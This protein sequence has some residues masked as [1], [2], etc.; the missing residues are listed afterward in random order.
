MNSKQA[1]TLINTAR[2]AGAVGNNPSTLRA[3]RDHLRKTPYKQPVCILD[4]GCGPARRHVHELQ[5]W[6]E[7][8]GISATVYGLDLADSAE[9][10]Q[11]MLAR[12]FNVVYASN[13]LN[14]Q[15]N[16]PWLNYT[17][18]QLKNYAQT[19][20]TVFANYPNNPRKLGWNKA[21]MREH[22]LSIGFTLTV[23]MAHKHVWRLT[24]QNFPLS[25]SI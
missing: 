5:Q 15:P 24:W 16:I 10:Q 6:C 12:T 23:H 1:Q 9:H 11:K 25:R 8:Q 7:A 4:Y 14:V 17:L 21:T 20:A 13:V 18:N 3:V 22:L 19:G 2:A